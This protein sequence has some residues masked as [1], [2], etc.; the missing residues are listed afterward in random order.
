MLEL[1]ESVLSILWGFC[2]SS[3]DWIEQSASHSWLSISFK[4]SPQSARANKSRSL[5]S[6]QPES[7]TLMMLLCWLAHWR[8]TRDPLRILPYVRPSAL[9][10][11]RKQHS[12]ETSRGLIFPRFYGWSHGHVFYGFKFHCFQVRKSSGDGKNITIFCSEDFLV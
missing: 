3:M 5:P 12:S 2:V 10:V 1:R 8:G 6:R 9:Y 7:H 4:S 11:A